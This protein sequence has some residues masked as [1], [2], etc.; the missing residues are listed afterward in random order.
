MRVDLSSSIEDTF[1]YSLKR[2]GES[3]GLLSL[4]F[5]EFRRNYSQHKI[6]DTTCERYS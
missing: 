6:S 3:N 1:T 2:G 4:S 5:I